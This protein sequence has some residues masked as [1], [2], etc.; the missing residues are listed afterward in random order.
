[1]GSSC[2]GTLVQSWHRGDAATG[3]CHGSAVVA[4]VEPHVRLYAFSFRRG[5]ACVY[6][7]C[8]VDCG[9]TVSCSYACGRGCRPCRSPWSRMRGHPLCRKPSVSALCK[10]S[11]SWRQVSISQLCRKQS[12]SRFSTDANRPSH[13]S[14]RLVP[15][16]CIGKDALIDNAYDL[17]R[18][19]ED[20]LFS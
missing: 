7:L 19:Y 4:R 9:A 5:N 6:C 11:T 10:E 1:M 12:A 2:P 18:I 16:T 14:R 17:E 3:R 20:L 15:E 13:V 8:N